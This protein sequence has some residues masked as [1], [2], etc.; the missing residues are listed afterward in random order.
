[1]SPTGP[2]GDR[3]DLPRP[4]LFRDRAPSSPWR[5]L[6]VGQTPDEREAAFLRKGDP[7]PTGCSA[8]RTWFE[9]GSSLTCGHPLGAPRVGYSPVTAVNPV[10]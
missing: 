2:G 5:W 10:E 3:R 6:A 4:P 1:M 9:A 7:P 8:K